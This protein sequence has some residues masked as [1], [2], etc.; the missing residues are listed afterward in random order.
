MSVKTELKLAY[1][2]DTKNLIKNAI[3]E[4]GQDVSDSDTFRSYADKILAIAG[5]GETD[6]G[7]TINLDRL[8]VVLPITDIT[9]PD[10]TDGMVPIMQPLGTEV[11]SIYLI[12][13]NNVGYICEAQAA[14]FQG[15]P[16]IA[17][18]NLAALGGEN[19]GE[20]FAIGEFPPEVAAQMGGTYGGIIPLDGSTSF[21]AGGYFIGK[22]SSETILEDLPVVLDFSN[23]NQTLTAPDGYLVK[24]AI[25]EKPAT[26]LPE[27]I[28]SGIDIAGVVGSAVAGGGAT[29]GKKLWINQK[30]LKISSATV[31][32]LTGVEICPPSVKDP[33]FIFVYKYA[34][35]KKDQTTTSMRTF[36]RAFA[37]NTK[38]YEKFIVSGTYDDLYGDIKTREVIYSDGVYGIGWSSSTATGMHDTID[39]TGL[40]G[41]AALM[42]QGDIYFYRNSAGYGC[43]DIGLPFTSAENASWQWETTLTH[44]VFVVAEVAE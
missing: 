40:T 10:G 19:T 1:L 13:W 6:A 14:E 27:N 34:N 21:S 29:L 18:G 12:V 42:H 31:G 26:L 11:G 39:T 15:V 7:V 35:K 16:V 17:I 23:G 22:N 30:G 20:P 37:L 3:I 8:T 33:L 2:K 5:G 24:S 32:R 4:K 41:E 38:D 43:I 25:I 44:Y 9:V 28:L 36:T